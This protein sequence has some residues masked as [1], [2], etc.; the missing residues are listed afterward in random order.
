MRIHCLQ[1]AD[2]EGL[3]NIMPWLAGRGHKVTC[4]QLHKNGKL[5]P[6]SS[7]DWLI[8]MGGPMN[9]DEEQKYRWLKTE[10]SFIKDSVKSGKIV[11]GVCLGAQLIARC[12]GAKVKKNRHKEIGWHKVWLTPAGKKSILFRGFP[13]SFTPIHW[14]GDTFALPR[15]IKS[16]ASSAAC[17]N[18]AFENSGRVFAVQFHIEYSPKHIR[19]FFRFEKE[20]EVKGKYEQGE[21][22]IL[23]NPVL[24]RKLKKFT[25]LMLS[26][27]ESSFNNAKR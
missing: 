13:V 16:L 7:F 9:A 11:L 15:G 5:P 21:K 6:M 12:L 25:E 10:K 24:F 2:S 14:H 3:A 8:I 4:T 22:Q 19:D 23:S 17:K 20:S 26:N 18:Q 1:H 27:I